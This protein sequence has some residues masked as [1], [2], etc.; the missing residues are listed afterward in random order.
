MRRHWQYTE[1]VDQEIYNSFVNGLPIVP[2][3]PLTDN[4]AV[5]VEC[6]NGGKRLEGIYDP[7][8]KAIRELKDKSAPNR[9]LRLYIDAVRTKRI[10]MIAVDG[11]MGTGKTSTCVES[12]IE[13]HLSNVRIPNMADDSKLNIE[14]Q[15][16]I[17]KPYINAGGKDEQY[18]FLPG[19][20]ND[21]LDPTI[22]NFI[23]YFDRYSQVGFEKLRDAGYI[24]ILPLG[25]IRGLD[26]KDMTIIADE[27]QNTKELV[28]LATR[29]ANRARI[30]FLGDTSPFQID[31]PGNTSKK[32]GLNHIIDLLNGAPYFQYIEMKTL[33]HIVRSVEVRD[34]VRR[35]FEKYGESPQDWII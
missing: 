4:L 7:D 22:S 12:V 8:I 16:F 9:D 23:Q 28:S 32:N 14:H 31:R 1:V 33:Q 6:I 13:Q 34:I 10:T 20:I 2:S 5:F 27:T 19:D 26:A 24:K 21:K 25:Y 17:C 11:L 18:G 15:I 30:F 29:K 35:L 3:E